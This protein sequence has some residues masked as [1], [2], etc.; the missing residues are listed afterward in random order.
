VHFLVFL[1]YVYHDSW[2]RGCKVHKSSLSLHLGPT[3]VVCRGRL[4]CDGTRAETRF[5]LSAK[6]TSPFKSAGGR[7]FSRLLAAEVCASAVVMLDTPCSEVVW[8]VLATH[9]IRQ[10]PLH[11]PPV[12]Q[13]VP[14]YFN[15]TIHYG[16]HPS[17]LNYPYKWGSQRFVVS[18]VWVL[19]YL[20]ASHPGPIHKISMLRTTLIQIHFR[21]KRG[22]S[23]VYI[24]WIWDC[25]SSSPL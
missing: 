1:R 3:H 22:Q 25:H 13:R 12:L 19:T 14:S 10:L 16:W 17:T 2:F 15:W 11:F 6:R 4:K 21:H 24:R 20:G 23:A 7:Q 9:S 8:R 18:I 5:R